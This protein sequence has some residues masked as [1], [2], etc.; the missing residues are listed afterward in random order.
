MATIEMVEL[1]LEGSAVSGNFGHQ[2]QPGHVGGS[3][4]GVPG[5]ELTRHA[6]ARMKERRKYDS[7]KRATRA[8][9]NVVVPEG[10][11]YMTMTRKGRP[12]G[13]LVGTGRA[14]KT[15]LPQQY[16]KE[17]LRGPDMADTVTMEEAEG[18]TTRI[19]ARASIEY[20]FANMTNEQAA[21]FCQIAELPPMTVEALA[22]WWQDW[23]MD[24]LAQLLFVQTEP[25]M[26]ESAEIIIEDQDSEAEIILE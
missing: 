19:D 16:K 25:E 9:D 6:F 8:L 13:F 18:D 10:D 20:Q 2:G 3:G 4:A 12:D 23:T 24:G 26:I 15:I 5:V 7:V 21:L 17:K 22:D 1:I 14:V 11:W